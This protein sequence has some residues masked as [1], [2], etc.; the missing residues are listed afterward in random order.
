MRTLVAWQR[1]DSEWRSLRRGTGF[2]VTFRFCSR[3]RIGS[4]PLLSPRPVLRCS[5]SSHPESKCL[6]RALASKRPSVAGYLSYRLTPAPPRDGCSTP[7]EASCRCRTD[8]K[9]R[10]P[11]EHCRRQMSLVL[12]LDDYVDSRGSKLG[13]HLKN[14]SVRAVGRSGFEPL[15]A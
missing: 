15:K 6:A 1:P 7:E 2:P 12:R 13:H 10:T 3:Q 14:D 5:L 9:E 4:F 11:A 8:P